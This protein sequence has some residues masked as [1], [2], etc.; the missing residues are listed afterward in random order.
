MQF[1]VKFA[2]SH[3]NLLYGNGR[4]HMHDTGLVIEGDMRKFSIPLIASIYQKV[5]Y[6]R[7]TQTIPYSV[8]SRHLP[9]PVF[10]TVL[11]FLSSNNISLA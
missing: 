5:L 11:Y 6:V 8:I 9:P 7:T 2:P 1:D 3:N 4:I 10:F